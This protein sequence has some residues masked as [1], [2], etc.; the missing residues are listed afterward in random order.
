MGN[1]FSTKQLEMSFRQS[2]PH[3]PRLEN[4]EP[5]YYR[6]VVTRESRRQRG[7]EQRW[8][9]SQIFGTH[10][11]KGK[12]KSALTHNQAADVAKSPPLSP[13]RSRGTIKSEFGPDSPNPDLRSP[14]VPPAMAPPLA[15]SVTPTAEFSFDTRSSQEDSKFTPTA[16]VLKPDALPVFRSLLA[17]DRTVERE[18]KELEVV[19]ILLA[20]RNK[21]SSP[22]P[23]SAQVAPN[24]YAPNTA[25]ARR[26]LPL[27][28]HGTG[29]GRLR[30]LEPFHNILAAV[31]Q[32]ESFGPVKPVK[33][34]RV[35]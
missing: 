21:S 18:E 15:N 26:P 20:M 1:V 4:A 12:L 31:S 34:E 23:H 33:K 17:D 19:G 24:P 16:A 13:C 35:F 32:E 2:R 29:A 14:S 7:R 9:V 8:D 10:Y 5:S 3:P 25:V 28:P 30:T 27:H 11:L 22:V 6:N